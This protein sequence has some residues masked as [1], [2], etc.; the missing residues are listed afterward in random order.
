M[1]ICGLLFQL[2]STRNLTTAKVLVCR[3][4]AKRTSSSNQNETCTR[5]DIAKALLI[6]R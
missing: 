2:A 1:F 5:H 3:S 4:N 6:L